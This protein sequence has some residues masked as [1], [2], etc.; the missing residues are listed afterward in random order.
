MK[1]E[2]VC[3]RLEKFF[4]F[5]SFLGWLVG[6]LLNRFLP[7]SVDSMFAVSRPARQDPQILRSR[8]ALSVLIALVQQQRELSF[9][10]K[11]TKGV[12]S[13]NTIRICIKSKFD[14]KQWLSDKD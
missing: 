14:L 12:N 7:G 13:I 6:F 3:E 9:L 11:L 1:Q 8:G 4:L 10:R 2:Q 5:F